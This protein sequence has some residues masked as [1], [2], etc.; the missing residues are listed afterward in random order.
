MSR[1]SSF[2]SSG[3]SPTV[4]HFPGAAALRERR[5]AA[6]RRA[7]LVVADGDLSVGDTVVW[8]EQR[9]GELLSA[10]PSHTLGGHVAVA[11]LDAAIAHPGS[12]DFAIVSGNGRLPIRTV[13]APP[14]NNRSLFVDPQR[15]SYRTR[16]KDVFP[17]LVP[18]P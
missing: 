9:I 5:A 2:S 1:R 7:T 6:T 15:H 12:S 17:P 14:V 8:G 10:S 4:E 11:L 16:D 18:A 3:G 13:S